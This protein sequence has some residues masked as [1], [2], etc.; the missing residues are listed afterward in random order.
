MAVGAD[1]SSLL[2]WNEKDLSSVIKRYSYFIGLLDGFTDHGGGEGYIYTWFTSA[3]YKNL[4][5]YI[6]NME[7]MNI[8]D[9]YIA[10]FYNDLIYAVVL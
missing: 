10:I 5:S 9:A 1:I 7:S 4:K 2:D 6:G 3:F 8:R